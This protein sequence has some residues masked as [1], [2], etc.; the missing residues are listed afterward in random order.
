MTEL[1]QLLN[2]NTY[3]HSTFFSYKMKRRHVDDTNRNEPLVVTEMQCSYLE[4]FWL[5]KSLPVCSGQQHD[6]LLPPE[7]IHKIAQFFTVQP[8]VSTDVEAMVASSTSGQHP[9]S[10]ALDESEATWWISEPG[11]MTR[12]IGREHIEFRLSPDNKL[13]RL[14]QFSIKVP[15][16][17]M[18]PLSVRLLFLET[19]VQ[20][21]L[22]ANTT[23]V[24]QTT[25]TT[26]WV[27]ISPDWTVENKT[28]WQDYTLESLV[29]AQSVRV[30]CL[31]NQM[32]EL[33]CMQASEVEE[34]MAQQ[35][36]SVGFYCVKFS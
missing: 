24:N 18:G 13:C 10:A 20:T 23:T 31:A 19:K 3:S 15:P 34:L 8:V 32:A 16:L 26:T 17:P 35:Y 28:G 7:I 4:L 36:V 2:P 25:T 33:M 12:G 6:S 22:R 30:V 14:N 1:V 29:D 9:I 21:T 5:I 27:R 11:S